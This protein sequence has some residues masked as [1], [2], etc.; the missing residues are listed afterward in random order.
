ME[1]RKYS[2]GILDSRQ[3]QDLHCRLNGTC[4]TKAVY[5]QPIPNTQIFKSHWN[6]ITRYCRLVD[7]I[8]YCIHFT[9]IITFFFSIIM[10]IIIY[11]TTKFV[12]SIILSFETHQAWFESLKEKQCLLHACLT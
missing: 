4:L 7:Y 12:M 1:A 9:M 6:T 8:Q 2:L 5:G 3:S 10:F 11:F